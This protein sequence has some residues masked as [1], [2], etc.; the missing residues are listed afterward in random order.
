MEFLSQISSNNRPFGDIGF[1]ERSDSKTEELDTTKL[2]PQFKKSQFVN[3][4]KYQPEFYSNKQ[5]AISKEN[6]PLRNSFQPSF[7]TQ[8]SPYFAKATSPSRYYDITEAPR[9]RT[10]LKNYSS[11]KS[12]KQES[13]KES[14]L[15]ILNEINKLQKSYENNNEIIDEDYSAYYDQRPNRVASEKS[16]KRKVNSER[17]DENAPL[18]LAYDPNLLYNSLQNDITDGYEEAYAYN[19]ILKEQEA[20]NAAQSETQ[21]PIQP[22]S[23]IKPY[24]YPTSQTN[25]VEHSPERNIIA[26]H[27]KPL[28]FPTNQQESTQ[29]NPTFNPAKLSKEMNERVKVQNTAKNFNKAPYHESYHHTLKSYRQPIGSNVNQKLS[30]PKNIEHVTIRYVSGEELAARSVQSLNNKVTNSFL[31]RARSKPSPTTTVATTSTSHQTSKLSTSSHSTTE[32]L[33]S[34]KS[35]AKTTSIADEINTTPKTRV[36][37]TPGPVYYKDMPVVTST[38][39]PGVILDKLTAPVNDQPYNQLFKGHRNRAKNQRYHRKDI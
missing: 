14:N 26:D 21:E 6:E 1:G 19:N 39:D 38:P 5:A 27:N 12:T 11:G 17:K 30:N 25:N 34:S 10:L 3:S 29:P 2:L 32:Q 7:T 13:L 31:T 9:R 23:L 18:P 8:T 24:Q 28:R 22:N 36:I 37:Y 20:Y 16:R 35:D 33:S 4:L 15:S